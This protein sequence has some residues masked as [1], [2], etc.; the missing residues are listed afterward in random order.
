VIGV[1]VFLLLLWGQAEKRAAAVQS[2]TQAEQQL[3]SIQDEVRA[4]QRQALEQ[5]K[6]AE[7]KRKEVADLEV[8]AAKERRNAKVAAAAARHTQYASDIQF[9]AAAWEGDDVPQMLGLLER[10]VP[11]KGSADLRGFEWHYL[12]NQAERATRNWQAFPPPSRSKSV[13]VMGRMTSLPIRLALSRDGKRLAVL[14]Q[15]V[16][17]TKK[18]GVQHDNVIK[19]WDVEPGKELGT[20]LKVAGAVCSMTFDDEGKHLRC[21][22]LK[23][24]D[25]KEVGAAWARVMAGKATPTAKLFRKVVHEVVLPLQGGRPQEA[26]PAPLER[27]PSRSSFADTM[28]SLQVQ[29][30]MFLQSA[31]ATPLAFG[32]AADGKTLVAGGF[33]TSLEKGSPTV[34]VECALLF[35]DVKAD[36]PVKQTF[37]GDDLITGLA[38]APKGVVVATAHIDGSVRLWTGLPGPR[39]R[40]RGHQ[41]LITWVSFAGDG[42]SLITG[43]SNGTVKVWDGAT[44]QL[45]SVFKGHK[46]SICGAVLAPNGRTLITADRKGLVKFWDVE[47]PQGPRWLEGPKGVLALQFT[48]DGRNLLCAG[49]EGQAQRF[50]LLTN[51]RAELTLPGPGT[52]VAFSADGRY[53][54]ACASRKT[55]HLFETATGR[56]VP[57]PKDLTK[58]YVNG[59]ALSPDGKRLAL[60]CSVGK[61]NEWRALERESGAV[62]LTGRTGPGPVGDVAFAPTGRLLALVHS[63]SRMEVWDLET[64]KKRCALPAADTLR[65]RVAFSPQGNY[66]ACC[67]DKFIRLFETRKGQQRWQ[68]PTYGHHP[69]ALAFSK[70]GRRLATGGGEGELSI[71][72]GVKLWDVTT[73][74]ELLTLGSSSQ[75]FTQVAFSPDGT[76]LAAATGPLFA[77]APKSPASRI[78]IWEVPRE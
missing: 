8:A 40:V 1:V 13:K 26:R 28:T 47:V 17:F 11:K 71:G 65:T 68:A 56:A 31:A 25:Y 36:R 51:K 60:V 66:L 64:R 74:R 72:G 62:V 27:W 33:L 61:E 21:V 57:L 10:Y 15:D 42:Q 7:D 18:M 22:V 24:P 63:A 9:A 14:R 49:R 41:G 32:L 50:D 52:M 48:S 46:D 16:S 2:L 30:L 70:D 35:W 55:V 23:T 37:L 45:R 20:L 3:E 19:L 34:R 44:G 12:R 73:G 4:A 39:Y 69:V 58:G 6:L 29:P 38:C 76:R 5:K 67:D 75:A 54:A 78:W 59:L 77:V 53:V 43:A